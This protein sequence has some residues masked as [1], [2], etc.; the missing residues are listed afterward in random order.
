MI[1]ARFCADQV[2]RLIPLPFFPS[3][4]KK[5]TELVKMLQF[6][7]TELLVIATIDSWLESN[8]KMPTPHDLREIIASLNIEHDQREK[9]AEELI[10]AHYRCSRCQDHGFYGGSI[11]GRYA[12]PWHWCDCGAAADRRERDP[13][14]VEEA[15]AERGRLIRIF[16]PRD[17]AIRGAMRSVV[18]A[19]I[20]DGY[21][22]DF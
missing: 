22:G 4:P 7:R 8:S 18:T 5:Q 19:A 10:P 9:R 11:G 15:N 20:D 21:T 1:D 6:A 13:D 3:E 16:A 12:G 17:P 2:A 14:L